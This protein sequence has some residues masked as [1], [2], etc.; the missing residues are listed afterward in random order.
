[1]LLTD[2]T[3]APLGAPITEALGITE[4]VLWDLEV[5][6]NRPDAMSVAGVARDLAGLLGV[7]F[8]FPERSYAA[9][10]ASVTDEAN[11]EIVDPSLCGRF[12]ARTLHNVKVGTSPRWMQQRLIALGMRP[13]N[14]VVDISNYVMLELGQPNHT[15]DLD[16]VANGHIRVRRATDGEQVTTLDG[17]ERTL[18]TNDGV[19][20][21][22]ADEAIGLAGVMGGLDTEISDSTTS[23]AIAEV[24]TGARTW[25]EL[26]IDSASSWLKLERS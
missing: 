16:T 21:N 19:I 3:D 10:D 13:I 15:Y 7:P 4:D 6:A 1:M 26:P 22:G 12:L 17:N 9:T 25:F 18:V 14:S 11:I 8:S 2:T 23:V 20:A 24:S 5:N